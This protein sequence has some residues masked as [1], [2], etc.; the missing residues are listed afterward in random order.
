MKW[1]SN[2]RRKAEQRKRYRA[3]VATWKATKRKESKR[4]VSSGQDWSSY[5]TYS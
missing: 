2:K 1:N 4:N 5:L 3:A